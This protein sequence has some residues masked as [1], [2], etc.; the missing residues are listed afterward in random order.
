MPQLSI[1]LIIFILLALLAIRLVLAVR[2]NKAAWP[3]AILVSAAALQALFISL[4]WDFG[5]LSVR[6]LQV[7][8]S[9]L[10]PAMAWFSFRTFTA[11]DFKRWGW[12]DALQVVPA[13]LCGVALLVLPDAIDFIIISVFVGYG[14]ACLRLAMCGENALNRA[15]LAGIVDVQRALWLVTFSLFASALVDLLV[16][17]DFLRANGVHAPMLIGLGNIVWLVAIG[18]SAVLTTR[19]IPETE[20][21]DAPQIVTD[22]EQKEDARIIEVAK[23]QLTVGGLAKDPNLTLT[24]LARRCGLPARQI[25]RAVNRIQKRNVSQFVN[26]IRVAEACRLLRESQMSVTQVIY[27]SGFQTKSNFNREFLRVTGKTP[28][29]WRAEVG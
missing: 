2:D 8:L 12:T 18:L 17:L 5:L 25:S 6:P 20:D 15:S 13:I 22:D 10:L 1:A 3:F 23:H 19:S 29:Q 4:R 14:T 21:E 9:C 11:D 24:R 16:V 28:R 27:D 26:D 7:L